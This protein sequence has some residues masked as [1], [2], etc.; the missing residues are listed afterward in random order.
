MHNDILTTDIVVLN[1][2]K[3]NMKLFM[4]VDVDKKYIVNN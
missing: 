2:R 4:L 1:I 3:I